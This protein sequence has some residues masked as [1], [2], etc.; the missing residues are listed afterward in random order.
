MEADGSLVGRTIAGRFRIDRCI[1][2]GGMATVYAAH[3]ESGEHAGEE[4]AVK[5]VNRELTRDPTVLRRFN[6]EAKAAA[7]LKHPNTVEVYEYGVDGSDAFIAM[8]LAQ[9][10]DLL[11]ALA[12]EN[13]MRQ[14]RAALVVAGICSGLA[15]A[16]AR[17]IVHRDLKPENVML[18]PM[19]SEPGGERV[20][21]LDFGIAK[22]VDS[23]KPKSDDETPSYVTRTALTR[24]G[25]IVGTP[26]YMSPEQCRGGELDGRSDVYSCGVLLYQILTGEVP[27]AGETP[28]HTAM[29]HIHAQPKPPSELRKTLA[30]ALEKVILKALAKWPGERHQ[31]A[32]ALRDELLALVP[33]LPDAQGISGLS[34][35]G[36]RG[37]GSKVSAR[38]AGGA[39]QEEA[40]AATE[41]VI[42]ADARM[43]HGALGAG[44]LGSVRLSSAG[45]ASATAAKAPP[46]GPA[47]SDPTPTDADA[48]PL[49]EPK[50]HQRHAAAVAPTAR[51]EV[52]VT[53]KRPS[54]PGKTPV[55]AGAKEAAA[56]KVNVLTQP[57]AARPGRTPSEPPTAERHANQATV[58]TADT[59]PPP[60]RPDATARLRPSRQTETGL[61]PTAQIHRERVGA[62]EEGALASQPQVDEDEEPRTFIRPSPDSTKTYPD[63]PTSTAGPPS[64]FSEPLPREDDEKR[65]QNNTL[66]MDEPAVPQSASPSAPMVVAPTQPLRPQALPRTLDAPVEPAARAHLDA[67]FDQGVV[68]GGGLHSSGIQPGVPL[69]QVHPSQQVQGALSGSVANHP[70]PL[71]RTA[72]MP[73]APQPVSSP[74]PLGA[75]VAQSEI[76]TV[77]TPLRVGARRPSSVRGRLE[78][79][80]GTALLLLGIAVGLFMALV[81]L[82]IVILTK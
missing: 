41:L 22:I 5:V 42:Q 14:A 24:V 62:I 58:G 77:S 29:R 71:K 6:R 50:T 40:L 55:M 23:G 35:L 51:G 74:Y 81:G 21:V 68:R 44:K 39:P 7:L 76:E 26:A 56:A 52:L 48:Q 3:V 46:L 19:P 69:S 25:T 18:V 13:P 78:D 49:V 38:A 82:L 79:F 33:T 61:T 10:K 72:R 16:H 32:E 60:Q 47:A 2:R 65:T 17:G 9:G 30:P 64:P 4:I 8:E 75:R 27:F 57:L 73:Y 20:K 53:E 67:A 37:A 12:A 80:S 45:A 63:G 28:L 43:L 15:A 11:Q 1:G 59:V 36:V 31:T 34:M 70:S 54:P 66:V